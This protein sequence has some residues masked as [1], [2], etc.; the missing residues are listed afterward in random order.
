MS[1]TFLTA[2][3]PPSRYQVQIDDERS[4]RQTTEFTNPY[5]FVGSC[6]GRSSK[7]S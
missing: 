7:T 6:A 2:H 5:A 3:L 1:M 4:F